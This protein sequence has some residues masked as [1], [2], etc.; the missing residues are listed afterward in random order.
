MYI[1]DSIHKK[2][3]HSPRRSAA[4]A[5]SASLSLLFKRKKALDINLKAE[6]ELITV[7][8]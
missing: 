4:A 8:A 5:T 2:R 3:N 6:E 1:N 7:T